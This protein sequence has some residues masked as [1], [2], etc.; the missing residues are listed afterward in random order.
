MSDSLDGF[1]VICRF[2]PDI[3]PEK[4]SPILRKVS[5]TTSHLY[6]WK[7]REEAT[8]FIK[9]N[10]IPMA[11]YKIIDANDGIVE[12]TIKS[13]ERLNV[14]VEKIKVAESFD[15]DKILNK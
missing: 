6:L 15:F 3:D 4:F 13:F 12:D 7:T 2:T 9:E 14:R 8:N 5:R 10:N 11:S 1:I